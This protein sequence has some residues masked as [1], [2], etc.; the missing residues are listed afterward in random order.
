MS[1]RQPAPS[2]KR[3]M[4]EAKTMA[5]EYDPDGDFHAAPIGDGDNLFDWHFTIRGPRDT[6][7]ENGIYH[8]RLLFPPDYPMKP[9]EIFL[10]TTSGR[11]ETNTKICLSISGYHPETW[12][13]SWSIS[14]ALIALQAFFIT[15]AKGA[16]G[17]I[18]W[19][20]EARRCA[21]MRSHNYVCKVCGKISDIL[22]VK[23]RDAPDTESR[24]KTSTVT[25]AN[26]GNEGDEN[27]KLKDMK[28][29]QNEVS[30][31]SDKIEDDQ[32]NQNTDSKKDSKIDENNNETSHT[33]K[34]KTQPKPEL[35]QEDLLK[36]EK[37]K[38]QRLEKR[39]Q[40]ELEMLRSRQEF[41]RNDMISFVFI[42]SVM[43]VVLF[44]IYRRYNNSMDPITY[45]GTEEL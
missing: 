1:A 34:A 11:F 10:L 13:P 2:V 15:D 29:E 32:T 18:N 33:T 5:K 16:I 6:P 27:L 20:A 41:Q 19:P 35:S 22:N 24:N 31:K 8:G 3:L 14:T 44:L 4:R 30:E 25:K 36:K 45:T 7:F 37:L 38:K 43:F 28:A 42:I 9:P 39:R 12:L 40:I 26:D 21:A 23:I 17:G